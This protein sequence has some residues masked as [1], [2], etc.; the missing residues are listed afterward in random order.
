MTN[1]F[2]FVLLPA[3]STAKS[4]IKE[5]NKGRAKKVRK[6]GKIMVLVQ[7]PIPLQSYREKCFHIGYIGISAWDEYNRDKSVIFRSGETK[8]FK[9]PS[10]RRKSEKKGETIRNVPLISAHNNKAIFLFVFFSVVGFAH[11]EDLFIYYFS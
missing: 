1:A 6:E 8:N 10:N 5:S 4:Q 7:L 3:C 2:S 9:N 11:K